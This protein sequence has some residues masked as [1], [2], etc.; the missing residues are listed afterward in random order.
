MKGD[1]CVLYIGGK[2]EAMFKVFEKQLLVH[3]EV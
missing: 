2:K 3:V 1:R